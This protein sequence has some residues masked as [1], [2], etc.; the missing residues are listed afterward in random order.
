VA[1]F[2]ISTIKEDFNQYRMHASE[3]NGENP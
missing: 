2:L 3:K 1:D